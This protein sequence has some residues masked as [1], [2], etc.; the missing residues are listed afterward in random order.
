MC[1]FVLFHLRI[2][3]SLFLGTIPSLEVLPNGF[4]KKIGRKCILDCMFYNLKL[5]QIAARM[6]YFINFACIVLHSQIGTSSDCKTILWHHWTL[7]ITNVPFSYLQHD[8]LTI[9][10]LYTEVSVHKNPVLCDWFLQP[11]T[12]GAGEK[13]LWGGG[14]HEKDCITASS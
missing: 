5:F 9:I 2:V 1:K 6:N 7:N 8:N 4:F 14:S 12:A 11:F 13:V 3:N 10:W